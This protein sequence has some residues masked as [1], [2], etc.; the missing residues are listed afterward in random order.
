MAKTPRNQQVA[1]GLS[2]YYPAANSSF[3][4]VTATRLGLK[5]YEHGIVYNNGMSPTIA[6]G[7]DVSSIGTIRRALFIPYQVKDGNWRLRFTIYISGATSVASSTHFISVNGVIFKNTTSF[8]Q[9]CA[10]AAGGQTEVLAF[11]NE[12]RIRFAGASGAPSDF[13]VYGDVELESKP[14]WAY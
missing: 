12:N 5:I 14:T 13:A 9:A 3:D 11:P 6:A 7:A 1:S 4:D 8:Y 2:G 10:G